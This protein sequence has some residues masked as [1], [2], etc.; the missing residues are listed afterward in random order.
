VRRSRTAPADSLNTNVYYTS[1]NLIL[2]WLADPWPF[3]KSGTILTGIR[4]GLP[5]VL[6]RASCRGPALQ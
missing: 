6:R 3:G 5:A 4:A 1:K 2:K